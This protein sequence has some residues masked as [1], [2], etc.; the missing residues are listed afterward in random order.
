MMFECKRCGSC[1][2]LI[3]C[4]HLRLVSEGFYECLIYDIRP[5]MCRFGYGLDVSGL[6]E[7][8]YLALSY[9]SCEK[10]R[11]LAKEIGT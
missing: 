4:E 11:E 1:C 10:L 6:S 7:E 2:K 5:E 9:E 8:E 3:G